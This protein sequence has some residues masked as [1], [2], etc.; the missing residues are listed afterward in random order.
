[1]IRKVDETTQSSDVGG[2]TETSMGMSSGAVQYDDRVNDYA[3]WFPTGKEAQAFIEL[4]GKKLP[5]VEL[6]GPYQPRVPS[7]EDH[8]DKVFVALVT[9]SNEETAKKIDDL[10]DEFYG[11]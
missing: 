5:H 8:R 4:A 11:D 10:V 3:W 6:Y 7:I 2:H 9:P 1:M